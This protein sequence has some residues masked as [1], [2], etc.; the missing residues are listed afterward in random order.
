VWEAAIAANPFAV[1]FAGTSADPAKAAAGTTVPVMLADSFLDTVAAGELY[2]ASIGIPTGQAIDS[3]ISTG[4]GIDVASDLANG[5][6]IRAATSKS[7]VQRQDL[8]V[9]EDAQAGG[10][11]TLWQ[12]FN[13]TTD[14]T[15]S[16]FS[17]QLGIESG[18]REAI[19]TLP[20][21]MLAFLV[22]DD[23]G[24][25][26]IAS[27]VLLDTQRADLRA[28]ASVSCSACHSPGLITVVDE[29]SPATLPNVAALGL[30][31]DQVQQLQAVYRT[32]AEFAQA[33]DR[34]NLIY[35]AA[36]ARLQLSATDPDPVAAAFNQFNKDLGLSDAAGDLGV[37]PASLR[38]NLDLLPAALAVLGTGTLTRDDF[39]RLYVDSLC[40]ISI[41]LDNQP[42]PAQCE[43]AARAASA[44]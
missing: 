38:V 24:K 39:A 12:A 6:Q 5:T 11:G 36:L 19:F 22:A 7:R 28:I 13:L 25:I 42:A 32:P 43:A 18:S 1:E 26:A 23:T 16:A 44:P 40:R 8:L 20:N 41:A 9:Q 37:T 15:Q 27:D 31:S 35:Q 33:I 4:L 21:G 30:S 2:Y 34:D 14:L 29:V 3:F 10:K 17:V